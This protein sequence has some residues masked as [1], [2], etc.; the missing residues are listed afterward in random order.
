MHAITTGVLLSLQLDVEQVLPK[1][2]A[3]VIAIQLATVH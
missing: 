3:K 2:Q 1:Q